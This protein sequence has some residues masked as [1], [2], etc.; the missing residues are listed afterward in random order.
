MKAFVAQNFDFVRAVTFRLENTALDQIVAFDLREP[1]DVWGLWV[2]GLS[3]ADYPLDPGMVGGPEVG[4]I[5]G[6]WLLS[7]HLRE[8]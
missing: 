3:R 7:I 8:K 6:T 2:S 4:S 5:A 1:E